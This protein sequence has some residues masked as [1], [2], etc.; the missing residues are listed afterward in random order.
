[1]TSQGKAQE[2][3]E[4]LA[5]GLGTKKMIIEALQAERDDMRKE[6]EKER[7]EY[8]EIGERRGFHKARELAADRA[9]GSLLVGSEH[10][11]G[12]LRRVAKKDEAQERRKENESPCQGHSRQASTMMIKQRKTKKQGKLSA[13]RIGRLEALGFV[14]SFR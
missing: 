6:M 4:K 5:A 12:R 3:W 14:W 11:T 10:N 7:D 9:D 2:L 1:M 8:Y 13:A